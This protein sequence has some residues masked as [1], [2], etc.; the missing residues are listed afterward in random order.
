MFDISMMYNSNNTTYMSLVH[1]IDQSTQNLVPYQDQDFQRP[2]DQ[3]SP[4][5]VASTDRHVDSMDQTECQ[6][7]QFRLSRLGIGTKG[8][9]IIVSTRYVTKSLVD[10]SS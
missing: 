7:A 9:R 3:S 4:I 1:C 2:H 5:V 6:Y 8:V 10:A